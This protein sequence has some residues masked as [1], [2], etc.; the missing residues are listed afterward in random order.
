MD[1]L[2]VEIRWIHYNSDPHNATGSVAGVM[3]A[4][5]IDRV[6]PGAYRL[7]VN[8]G[9]PFSSLSR[10]MESFHPDMEGAKATAQPYAAKFY[11]A[12]AISVTGHP[13]I[14]HIDK[15]ARYDF[16]AQL[17][18]EDCDFYGG[19]GQHDDIVVEKHAANAWT[20]SR[21]DGRLYANPSQEWATPA[22]VTLG[23]RGSEALAQHGI[24]VPAGMKAPWLEGFLWP[25]EEALEQVHFMHC[26]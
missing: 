10:G 5:V 17:C 4:F 13:A 3:D 15:V 22:T 2:N 24:D 20:I 26:G 14:R 23:K 6:L 8:L 18:H 21:A 11:R 19:D 9:R 12:F 7:K 1:N 25:L 16:P